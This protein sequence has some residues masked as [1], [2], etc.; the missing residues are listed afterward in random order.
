MEVNKIKG[1]LLSILPSIWAMVSLMLPIAAFLLAIG[2]LFVLE[3]ERVLFR[4]YS[5]P[6]WWLKLRFPMTG[7]VLILLMV[8][9][10][11]G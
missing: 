2:F 11:S 5:L 4:I 10:L 9:G 7:I 6:S 3:R 1:I 8:V